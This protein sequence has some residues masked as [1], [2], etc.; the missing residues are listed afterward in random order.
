LSFELGM[1][2]P[3]PD[4]FRLIIKENDLNPAE[5]VFIDDSE[6]NLPPAKNMGI[7]TIFLNKNIDIKDLFENGFL[8]PQKEI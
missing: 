3:D 5:T 6:Q 7:Q 8:L 1:R 4:F 2:K